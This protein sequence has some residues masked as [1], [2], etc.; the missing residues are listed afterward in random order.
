MSNKTL[1]EFYSKKRNNVRKS[2]IGMKIEESLQILRKSS[3]SDNN[4]T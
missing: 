3:D 1:Q 4:S 2:V